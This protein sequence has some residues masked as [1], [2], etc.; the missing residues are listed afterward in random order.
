MSSS[1]LSAAKQGRNSW[2]RYLIGI[3]LIFGIATIIYVP[4]V[5]ITTSITGFSL[6][7]KALVSRDPLWLMLSRAGAGL[8]YLVGLFFVMKRVHKRRFK[9]LISPNASVDWFRVV[10]AFGLGISIY[11][12]AFSCWYLVAP[13]RYSFVF[14][15]QE[16]I[17]F[18]AIALFAIG[19]AVLGYCLLLYGYGLQGLGLL[20]HRPLLLVI[21][22][23]LIFSLLPLMSSLLF[24]HG[25]KVENWIYYLFEEAFLL[26]LVLKDNRLEL[27][28][29]FAM[30]TSV[31]Y[32]LLLRS[33]E[34]EVQYPAIFTVAPEPPMFLA[35]LATQTLIYIAFYYL[36][37]GRPRN[38]SS[39]PLS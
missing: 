5:I 23:S 25:L 31:R 38:R 11:I 35:V 12:I 20:T 3:L 32:T 30:S 37:L 14:N 17:P 34:A 27:A 22:C 8:S 4:W 13:S 18:A 16:W 9:T 2:K 28:I 24:G 36:C 26:S 19:V 15:S 1:F 21:I 7:D 33:V 39:S 10:K 29:G 6:E